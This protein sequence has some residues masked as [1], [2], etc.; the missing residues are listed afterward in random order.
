MNMPVQGFVENIQQRQVNFNT[1]QGPQSKVAYDVYV[2]G[3]KY[4]SWEPVMAQIGDSVQFTASQNNKGYWQIAKGS[5]VNMGPAQ[6]ASMQQAPQAFQQPQQYAQPQQQAPQQAQPQ[7]RQSKDEYWA[8]KDML[9][10]WKGARNCAIELVGT[11]VAC[12]G[13]HFT[14]TAKPEDKVEVIEAAVEMYTRRFYAD[15]QTVKADGPREPEGFYEFSEE[16]SN[17]DD[18]PL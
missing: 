16:F 17:D 9:N 18:V 11:L 6:G 3:Q 4:G 1:A 10:D 8:E 15:L 7:Q 13:I 5:F 2:N 14:K 12:G